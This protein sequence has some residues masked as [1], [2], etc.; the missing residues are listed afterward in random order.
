MLMP[1]R[2]IAARFL[3]SLLEIGEVNFMQFRYIFN[4]RTALQTFTEIHATEIRTVASLKASGSVISK[5]A[6]QSKINF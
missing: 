1:I 6:E 3:Y 2:M 5:I 4:N